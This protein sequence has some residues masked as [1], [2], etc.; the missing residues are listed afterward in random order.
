MSAEQ[1]VSGFFRA[2]PIWR[3]ANVRTGPSL[4]SRI[5]ELLLP[6]DGADYRADAWTVGEEV[7]EG[8]IISDIWLRLVRGGWCSAVN[9]DQD[10]VAGIPEECQIPPN[11]VGQA[12]R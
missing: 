6:D 10:I 4:G 7:V 12:G 2:G 8:T 9:F 11:E 1:Q 3:D 5:I